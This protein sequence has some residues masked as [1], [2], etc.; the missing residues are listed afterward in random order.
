MKTKMLERLSEYPFPLRSTTQGP[1]HWF[2]PLNCKAERVE[3]PTPSESLKPHLIAS[4][5]PD[6]EA[7]LNRRAKTP[8]Y[9]VLYEVKGSWRW[10]LQLSY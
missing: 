9:A 2:Y 4:Q 8:Q 6:R 1:K 10:L 7:A 3:D 5:R